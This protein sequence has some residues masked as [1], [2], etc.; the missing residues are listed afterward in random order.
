[1][2]TPFVTVVIPTYNRTETLPRAINS[3][4]NQSYSNWELYIIDDGST[5]N[6]K[7]LIQRE[8]SSDSRIYFVERP[9]SRPK[10]ANSC[11]NI[12]A[13]EGSGKYVAYLD[14]DDEWLSEHLKSKVVK[15]EK[16]NAK[17]I[18]G[19]FSVKKNDD[20]YDFRCKLNKN[21]RVDYYLAEEG[22]IR[23]SSFVVER[24]AFLKIKFDEKL[25]KHQDWDFAL[26]FC[27]EFNYTVD[28]SYTTI[29]HYEKNRMSDDSNHKATSRF[30]DRHKEHLNCK[31]LDKIITMVGFATYRNEGRSEIFLKYARLLRENKYISNKISFSVGY[32]FP[33]PLIGFL[34]FKLIENYRN[35]R[36][37]FG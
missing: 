2:N 14:S 22:D 31:A 23:T 25:K 11:R 1:M 8:Y 12:G 29:L 34:W 37:S 15:L 26:R 33:I 18:F 19:S 21:K 28:E 13:E 20:V 30:L 4:I 24:S 6:T 7:E 17:F 32:I 16:T 10:G 27:D 3:V 9:V 36:K 35:L 5:D